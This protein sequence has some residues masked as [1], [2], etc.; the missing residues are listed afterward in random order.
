MDKL[1]VVLGKNYSTLLGAIRGAAEQGYDIDARYIA[2]RSDLGNIVKSSKYVGNYVHHKKRDEEALV[3]SLISTYANQQK[4][5][6]LIA[7]DDYTASVLSDNY[8]R[9]SKYFLLPYTGDKQDGQIVKLMDKSNQN[10][11]AQ[12]FGLKTAKSWCIEMVQGTYTIPDGIVYPCFYKPLV[13]FEGGKNG[14]KKCSTKDELIRELEK[15]KMLGSFSVLVQEYLEIDTEYSISGICF[16]NQV[17]LPAL[18][19]KLRVSQAHKGTTVQGIIEKYPADEVFFQ[20][21][22]KMLAS[23]DLYSI[24]DVEV[25]RCGE[26]IYFNEINIRT[27]AVCYGIVAGGVNIPGIFTDAMFKGTLDLK[28]Y[29]IQYGSIFLCDRAAW[30]DY[31]SEI[32]S[33]KELKK[34][35]S[36]SKYFIIRNTDDPK[37]ESA[38]LCAIV[39]RKIK[40]FI[41]KRLQNLRGTR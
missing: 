17:F 5:V 8:S 24:I 11:I 1:V 34:L 36:D 7:T 20:K 28:E 16:G 21:L 25:F 13:S 14:M 37:P 40:Y 27:S 23:L 19:R 32:I 38:F 31:N 3:E 35:Y 12:S 39:M 41:I 33:A 10:Q 18:L 4:E 9:L 30:D 22:L 6:L 26:Q 29:S 15:V 2:P